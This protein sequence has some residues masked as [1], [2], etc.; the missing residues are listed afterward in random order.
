MTDVQQAAHRLLDFL[1]QHGNRVSLQERAFA[2]FCHL[3]YDVCELEQ[4]AARDREIAELRRRL[5][6]ATTPVPSLADYEK[7]QADVERLRAALHDVVSGNWSLTMDALT[8]TLAEALQAAVVRLETYGNEWIGVLHIGREALAAYADAVAE[9]SQPITP[10]WLAAN[11]WA[12]T[13]AGNW[14]RGDLW[15]TSVGAQWAIYA[16]GYIASVATIG[17]LRRLVEAVACDPQPIAA[18]AGAGES[19]QAQPG[20]NH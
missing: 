11:G 6:T 15:A 13:D 4:L 17:Q 20:E 1:T 14:G 18:S 5:R 10:E 2:D 7:L 9:E 19:V 3:L 12:R 16:D 8:K